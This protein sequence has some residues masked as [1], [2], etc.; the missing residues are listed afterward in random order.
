MTITVNNLKGR[1]VEQT[2]DKWGRWVAHSYQGRNGKR[3]IFF[4]AYQGVQKPLQPGK[5]TVVAS[6]QQSPLIQAAD[7][8][9]IPHN[10]REKGFAIIL[11]G[12]F[13]E[14]FGSDPEGMVTI[15]MDNDLMNVM[16][17]QNSNSLPPTY[18][19]GNKCID[20]ALASPDIL[21]AIVSAGFEPL[22]RDSTQI[23]ELIS[24]ILTQH[25][26]SGKPH[27]TY[28]P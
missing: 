15:A 10:G 1:V 23:T 16:E 2:S 20:Y 6:Q 27:N 22:T 18:A 26:C 19:G 7:P 5:I 14:A 11:L 25:C 13:N 24:L 12:D 3:L 8:T 21:T 9:T 17:I 28:P 4:N